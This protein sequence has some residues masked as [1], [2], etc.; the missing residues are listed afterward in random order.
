MATTYIYPSAFSPFTSLTSGSSNS[1]VLVSAT[2]SDAGGA[3]KSATTEASNAAKAA[4]GSSLATFICHTAYLEQSLRSEQQSGFFAGKRRLV[5]A[6]RTRIGEGASFV[7]D[8]AKLVDGP[9]GADNRPVYVAIKTAR[10]GST[11]DAEDAAARGRR[12]RDTLFEIRA[13][14][15]QPLRYHP[16][17]VR[18][19]DIR[20]DGSRSLFPTLVVELAEFGTLH[21]LQRARPALPF[22]VKQK[23]CY[24]VGKGLSILHACGVVHGDLKHENVL[25]FANHYPDPPDQPYTAKLADFGGAVMDMAGDGDGDGD[26]QHHVPASTF[27]LDAPEVHGGSRLTV[28]GVKKTDAYSYGMLIWRC[29]L[30]CDDMFGLAGVGVA[31]P[32]PGQRPSDEARKAMAEAKEADAV[33]EWAVST[34]SARFHERRLPAPSLHLV[35]AALMFTLRGDPAHRALDRAQARMRG[36]SAQTSH[37]YVHVKDAANARTAENDRNATP[38]RHGLTLDGV[39]FGLGRMGDEY[40]AQNNLPGFRP[41]LP[42]P[43]R[44]GFVF[45]PVKLG[46]L[47]DWDHQRTI[48]AEFVAAAAAD[49]NLA[50]TELQPWTAAFFLYQCYLV[51]FGAPVDHASACRW[52]LAAADAA[53]E[54]ATVDYLARA[55][56]YRVHAALGIDNPLSPALQQDNLWWSIVRGHR[57]CSADL[58][59]LEASHP[60][61]EVLSWTGSIASAESLYRGSTASTGMPVFISRMMRRPWNVESIAALDAEII[62][63]LGDDYSSCLRRPQAPASAVAAAAEGAAEGGGGTPPEH[64]FDQ[65]FVNK[66]GHGL[67][68]L[69]ASMGAEAALRHMLDRYECDINLRNQSH[70]ETPLLCA[71]RSG[72]VPCALLLLDRG[73]DPTGGANYVEEAPLHCLF[74]LAEDDVALVAGRLLD[75]GADLEQVSGGM[76]Q[77]VRA[78]LADWQDALGLR[79]TPLGRAVL[80]QCLP[81]VRVLLARGADPLGRSSVDGDGKRVAHV[82]SPVELAAVLT[83]PDI[84]ETLLRAVDEREE[85]A[86]ADLDR[87]WDWDENDILEAAH[88]GTVTNFD[89][90]LMQSRLV[91]CGVDYKTDLARTLRIL[92]DRRRR[93]RP[94]QQGSEAAPASGRSLCA[95]AASRGAGLDVMEALLDLGHPVEGSPGWRPIQHAVAANN[96]PAYHLLAGRGSPLTFPAD[97]DADQGAT[98]LQ[99]FAAR[100][101]HTPAG[102]AIAEDLVLKGVA[103]RGEDAGVMDALGLAVDRRYFDLADLLISYGAGEVLN[104]FYATCNLGSSETR[105]GS[106]QGAPAEVPRHD[107]GMS[108]LGMKLQTHDLP[109]LESITYL[110]RVHALATAATPAEQSRGVQIDP[111]CSEPPAG[112]SAVHMLAL[113]P[114]ARW[115]SHAQ[116]SERIVQKVLDMFPDPAS[117]GP[118]AI[119]VVHGTP[120]AAAVAAVNPHVVAALLQSAFAVHLDAP[121]GGSGGDETTPVALAV[122]LAGDA[123]R[124]FEQAAAAAAAAANGGQDSAESATE[125]APSFPYSPGE[126]AQL[127]RQLDV[128]SMLAPPTTVTGSTTDTPATPSAEFYA[129]R[130]L[131][132]EQIMS[133][134]TSPSPTPTTLLSDA[135]AAAPTAMQQ[136]ES[137]A[138]QLS[139]AETSMIGDAAANMPVDLSV[140]TEE[141]PSGW[142]EGVEMDGRMAMRVFLKSFRSGDSGFGDSITGFMDKTFNTRRRR[143]GAAASA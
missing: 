38:G 20:W 100:P 32:A 68:H 73:A 138:N 46:A 137:H 36:M 97:A 95:E 115:N 4:R 128:A 49:S 98:L 55:W 27:P 80:Q 99:W 102:I 123:M 104:N 77:D 56:V 79:V 10:E 64:R 45:D 30:D 124:R 75:A 26:G 61:E 116:T 22:G 120:L 54:T 47:L 136:L 41:D 19:L 88:A 143:E 29:M 106:E 93:R 94:Q 89:P 3:I 7:V 17:V 25:I 134:A 21:G 71:V 122:R 87:D 92:R 59:A 112:L 39:G 118:H 91:R 86:L 1:G 125:P 28:E 90:L 101:G 127:R 48:L 130:M 105:G 76:R 129:A 9:V 96:E 57:H 18:L 23:L 141:V 11:A 132:Y 67:L 139:L 58:R 13:L 40:D 63:E 142:H 82:K 50:T 2:S 126:F 8:R 117:L 78:V 42:H 16:N 52:L 119:H 37:A 72:H 51:G 111:L 62:K 74:N 5:T 35:V 107:G 70:A 6:D 108:L 135:A 110:A 60:R 65:I 33:L 43:S 109:S 103:V 84:L 114:A 53:K 83:L 133:R 44:G 121:V 69:A 12:W 24:D 131:E 85:K 140:I 34:V 14:L 66:K 81:A 31:M 15:H 113:F